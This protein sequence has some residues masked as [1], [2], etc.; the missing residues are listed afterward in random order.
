MV[1]MK[2]LRHQLVAVITGMEV[3]L[4]ANSKAAVDWGDLFLTI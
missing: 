1:K 4:L 2:L 3:A